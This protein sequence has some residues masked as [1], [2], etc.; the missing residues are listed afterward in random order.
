MTRP[1]PGMR[2][3]AGLLCL[4][5][6]FVCTALPVGAESV[7]APESR[8]VGAVCLACLDNNQVLYEKDP[9]AMLYPASTVK[10]MTGLLCCRALAERLDERVT[11]S[12]S[13]L[14]GVTGRSLHLAVGETLTVRDLLYAALCGSYND[15]CSALAALVSGSQADFVGE[16]NREAA[17][18]GASDTRYVNPTGVH[19]ENMLTTLH[20]TVTIAREAY[21]N[22]LFMTITSASAYTIPATNASPERVIGNRNALLSDTSQVYHN[23]WCRGMSAGMT[24][25]GGW[26]VVTVYERGGASLLCVVMQGADVP[27]G[28][29]VPAYLYVN[30]LLSW[31]RSQYG[32]VEVLAPGTVLDTVRVGMTGLSSSKTKLITAGSLSVYLPLDVTA[33]SLSTS[34]AYA[35]QWADGGLTA[36]LMQG[37]TVGFATVRY[38]GE[39]VG[40]VPLTVSDS[41]KRNGFMGFMA[42]FRAYLGSR[43]FL[44]T[45][46]CFC[47]LLAL[48]IP[49]VRKSG[50]R[51]RAR[52]WK[53]RRRRLRRLL[54]RK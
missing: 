35:G 26:C 32:L 50:G 33:D 37:E 54:S 40:T 7:P 45:L 46:I 38:N 31:A 19:D 4:F 2:L 3:C 53:G 29:N 43:A 20:D 9:H 21:G 51:Y 12:S 23:G 18:L 5:L 24:D 11:L 39:I 25:E 41:F 16:M 47:A 13:M 6:L 8:E 14:S 15:A 42:G 27:S 49:L 30:S 10:I 44:I 36:P 1:S 17:R 52:T 22:E 28:V 34:W 48:Y